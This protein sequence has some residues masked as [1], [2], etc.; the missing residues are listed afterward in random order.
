V[1]CDKGLAAFEV[2]GAIA[3]TTT[4][5]AVGA[6]RAFETEAFDFGP[7]AACAGLAA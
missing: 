7:V 6:H 1:F 5:G 3:T 4:R 2:A